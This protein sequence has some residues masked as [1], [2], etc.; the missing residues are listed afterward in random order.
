MGPTYSTTSSLGTKPLCVSV[1]LSNGAR[2]LVPI[3][4]NFTVVQLVAEAARR[5]TAMN[6]LYD[7]T[8]ATLRS[9]DGSILFG[10][11][12]LKDILDLTETPQLLLGPADVHSY[13]STSVGQIASELVP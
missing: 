9:Q 12:S 7:A 8:E 2:I 3:N 5:A 6:L 10:E 4:E 1:T 13:L 11:D